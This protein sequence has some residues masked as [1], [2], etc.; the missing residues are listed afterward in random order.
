MTFSAHLLMSLAIS[1]LSS[2]Q[3]WRKETKQLAI[4]NM[5]VYPP[6]AKHFCYLDDRFSKKNGGCMILTVFPTWF[7]WILN[8]IIKFNNALTSTLAILA[9]LHSNL[10]A[11]IG[12]RKFSPSSFVSTSAACSSRLRSGIP[13]LGNLS[14]DWEFQ[15]RLGKSLGNWYLGIF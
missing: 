2:A 7:S 6:I 12:L 14:L 10:V 3:P 9:A 5:V 11:N 1:G 15:Q 4:R 8:F 13:L